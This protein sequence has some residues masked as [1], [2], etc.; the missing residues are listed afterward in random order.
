MKLLIFS[1]LFVAALELS[2]LLPAP[3]GWDEDDED[4]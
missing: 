1:L 2:N 3:K 4:E